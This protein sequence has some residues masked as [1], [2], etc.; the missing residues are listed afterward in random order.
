MIRW[1][2]AVLRALPGPRSAG[3]AL[4]SKKKYQLS[5]SW[6]GSLSASGSALFS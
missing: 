6:E 3:G 5:L 2:S 1:A 4:T